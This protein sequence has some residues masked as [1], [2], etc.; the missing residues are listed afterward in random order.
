MSS[1]TIDFSDEV[2]LV[3]GVTGRLGGAVTRALLDAGAHIAAVARRGD[4]VRDQIPEVSGGEHYIAEG[5]DVTDADSFG[6]AVTAVHERFGRID[7]LMHTV[8]GYHADHAVAETPIEDWEAMHSLNARSTFVACRAVLPSML[9]RGSGKIVCVAA[10]SALM[11]DGR[12]A[13]YSASK[14]AVIRLVEAIAEEVCDAGVNANCVLPSVIDTP[15]NRRAFPRAHTE[16]W[17]PPE[18]IAEVMLFLASEAAQA[19]HGAAI[20]VYGRS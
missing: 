18:Q 13:A 4:K 1:I 17:V 11:A 3:T 19:I 2:V 9:E 8:G 12:A 6:A 10:R 5:V 7:V 16:R 15:E 14:S 20:P